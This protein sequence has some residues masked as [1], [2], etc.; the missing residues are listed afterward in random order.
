MTRMRLER[1]IREVMT[2][3]PGPDKV[4]HVTDLVLE[5]IR[6]AERNLLIEI[7]KTLQDR[8]VKLRFTD[9]KGQIIH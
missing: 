1:D 3:N 2:N 9:E 6:L 7:N 4:A 8:K 5:K